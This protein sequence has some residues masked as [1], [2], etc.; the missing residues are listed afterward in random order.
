MQRH[1]REKNHAMPALV[2]PQAS[3][4]CWRVGERHGL[5]EGG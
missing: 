5:R 4:N 3:Q 2:N 1:S